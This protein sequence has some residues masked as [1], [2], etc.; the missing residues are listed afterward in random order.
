MRKLVSIYTIIRRDYFI[1]AETDEQAVNMADERVNDYDDE[2]MET[3]V[4][5]DGVEYYG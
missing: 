1:D 4:M 5:V 2:T 3:K